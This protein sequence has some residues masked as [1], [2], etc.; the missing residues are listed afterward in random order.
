[1]FPVRAMV[2]QIFLM[3]KLSLTLLRVRAIW[4]DTWF[5]N[6]S[7]KIALNIIRQT[8]W[9]KLGHTA[10]TNSPGCFNSIPF[11]PLLSTFKWQWLFMD[12][13]VPKTTGYSSKCN[14]TQSTV[15][16][17][18]VCSPLGSYS[19]PKPYPTIQ[20]PFP[21]FVPAEILSGSAH[22]RSATSV[23]AVSYNQRFS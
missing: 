12:S 2:T 5:R 3:N 20:S 6:H 19:P 18:P 8:N 9:V 23:N 22:P 16:Q 10:D 7:L 21:L 4:F 15:S 11:W 17:F 1:M 14:A 13:R